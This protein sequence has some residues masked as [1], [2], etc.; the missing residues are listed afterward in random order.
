MLCAFPV[1]AY[2]YN[3]VTLFMK[4][5]LNFVKDQCRFDMTT[6]H[7]ARNFAVALEANKYLHNILKK[8]GWRNKE[9]Q[10]RAR[11]ENHLKKNTNRSIFFI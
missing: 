1:N 7:A 3:R 5:N 6:K 8:Y 2:S 11:N 9:F 10:I 4:S